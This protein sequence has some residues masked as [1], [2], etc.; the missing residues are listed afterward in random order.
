MAALARAGAAWAGAA[1]TEAVVL[2]ATAEMQRRRDGGRH[3]KER[4][5]GKAGRWQLAR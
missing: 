2:K 3:W 4:L 5:P 1:W